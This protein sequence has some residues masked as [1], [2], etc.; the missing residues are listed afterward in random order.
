ML[1]MK[2]GAGRTYP[3]PARLQVVPPPD[4]S[5]RSGCWQ[6]FGLASL[7]AFAAFLRPPLPSPKASA[8]RGRRS[9]LPLR[10][11]PGFSPEFP[12]Q[13]WAETQSTNPPAG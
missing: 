11:N 7:S 4:F 2:L 5:R 12:F 6:V 1:T 13:P 9:R 3:P 10:G 8:C